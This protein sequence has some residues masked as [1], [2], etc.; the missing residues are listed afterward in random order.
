[1]LTIICFVAYSL[2]LYRLP[3]TDR[4]EGRFVQAT[5]QMIETGDY[6][7]IKFQDEFRNKKP[8][9]IY[10]LQAG[11][12]KAMG[13][14]LNSVWPYRLPSF[15]CALLAVLLTYYLAHQIFSQNIALLSA[16]FMASSTVII[17]EATT[18]KTD[19]ALLLTTLASM[20][21]VCLGYQ[22]QRKRIFR[23]L[24]LGLALAAGVM[25]KGP[26]TLFFFTTTLLG[27]LFLDQD[28]KWLKNFHW[29]MIAAIPLAIVLPWFVLIQ[30][31]TDGQFIQGSL[32]A[33]FSKK[34]LSVQEGHGALPGFYLISLFVGLWSAVRWLFPSIREAWSQKNTNKS[35]RFCLAAI[36]PAFIILEF[37][38]T[39]LIH[40]P[41]PLYPWL[42]MLAA[43][44]FHQDKELWSARLS[45]WTGYIWMGLTILLAC[46]F[47]FI[48]IKVN[49]NTSALVTAFCLSIILIVSMIY[50][51]KKLSP[52]PT[53]I[54]AIIAFPL[55]LSLWLPQL[56]NLWLTEQIYQSIAPDL[57][58]QPKILLMGYGEPSAVFRLGTTIVM[59]RKYQA[60]DQFLQSSHGH[61]FIDRRLI[62]GKLK[63]LIDQSTKL[64]LINDINGI[65]YNKMKSPQLKHYI[66]DN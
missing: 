48:T 56:T 61:L 3:V 27:L 53:I 44:G 1:M 10:W 49:G 50:G 13:Q 19:A 34:I 26:L 12:V 20:G 18:A 47:L 31:A 46:S 39:K 22:D 9:G 58:S 36:L 41:L 16:F 45:K 15:I 24:L 21:L 8:A 17:V 60:L 51:S 65:N 29:L 7:T 11:A 54:G 66:L 5:K 25:I 30:K 33:D 32:G 64:R 28:K 55:G 42:V 59:S 23:S 57:P 43:W 52:F 6:L 38:P 2:S 14:P 37:I 35:I 4:D 62:K 40:Y 63:N